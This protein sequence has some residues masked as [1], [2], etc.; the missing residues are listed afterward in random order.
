MQGNE[1]I[2]ALVRSYGRLRRAIWRDFARNLIRSFGDF[3]FSLVQM[4]TLLLLDEEGELAIK[5]VAAELERSVSATSRMLDQLVKRGLVSRR[6]NEGDR[7]QKLVAITESGRTLLA[8]VERRRVDAQLKIMQNLSA[9][10]R[11]EVVRAMTLIAGACDRR[12]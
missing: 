6:E 11:A 3:E 8:A 10:E 1:Q 7:R 5:Q 4:V 2:E 12:V 9:E